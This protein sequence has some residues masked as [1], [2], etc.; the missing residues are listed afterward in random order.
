MFIHPLHYIR[1]QL[2]TL[3]LD[4]ISTQVQIVIGEHVF[5]F[6]NQSIYNFK[7]LLARRIN[8]SQRP[9]GLAVIVVARRP[10]SVAATRAPCVDVAWCVKL[11]NDAH[12]ALSCKLNQVTYFGN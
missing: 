5:D 9:I 7:V 3:L 11:W 12:A 1:I 10:E 6:A 2:P 4:L 8:R